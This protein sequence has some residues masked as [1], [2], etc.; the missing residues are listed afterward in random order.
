MKRNLN[1]YPSTLNMWK[2]ITA[3]NQIFNLVHSFAGC[4][5]QFPIEWEIRIIHVLKSVYQDLPD[6]KL[7]RYFFLTQNFEKRTRVA[8]E[9]SSLSG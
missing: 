4:F 1:L 5:C 2:M 7:N 3:E 8:V 6:I 9:I